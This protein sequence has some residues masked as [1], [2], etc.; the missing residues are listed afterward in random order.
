MKMM[1]LN[2]N[3]FC[4]RAHLRYFSHI[5]GARVILKNLTVDCCILD[6]NWDTISLAS[7]RKS[8]RW[9]ISLVAVD[10]A[11]YSASVEDKA[12]S[13][14]SLDAHMSGQPANMIT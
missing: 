14:H 11:T 9:I 6:V 2:I 1:I 13:V 7:F 5:N 10:K 3:M 4:A 12:I 8:M